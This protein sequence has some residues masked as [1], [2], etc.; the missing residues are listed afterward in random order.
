MPCSCGRPTLKKKTRCGKCQYEQV[1]KQ[2]YREKRE[3]LTF[4]KTQPCTDCG[5]QYPPHVMDFDHV[6]GEKKFNLGRFG[7]STTMERLLE[8][9]SKCE[10]V[11]SNCHRHRTYLREQARKGKRD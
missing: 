3:V 7:N 11:C 2:R 6:V 1:D 10:V 8:E 9:V 4:F 5:Q